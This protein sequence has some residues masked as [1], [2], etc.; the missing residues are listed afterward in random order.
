M[1]MIV[2]FSDFNNSLWIQST[3]QSGHPAS[4]HYRDLI[5]KWRTIQYDPMLWGPESVKK[6]AVS[7]LVLQPK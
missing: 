5:E 1:R 4:P 6:A 2:D 3:G 7:T